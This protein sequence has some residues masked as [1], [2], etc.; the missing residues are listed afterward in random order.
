V[1]HRASTNEGDEVRC[2]DRS[3]AGLCGIAAIDVVIAAAVMLLVAW[4]GAAL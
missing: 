1:E 2:V 4:V 3:P